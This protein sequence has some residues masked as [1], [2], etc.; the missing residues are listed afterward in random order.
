MI[1][2]S[3]TWLW[4]LLP[5]VG[6]VVYLFTA[7]GRASVV[8]FLSLWGQ[9]TRP[10]RQRDWRMPPLHLLLMLLTLLLTVLAAANPARLTGAGMSEPVSIVLDRGLT[11]AARERPGLALHGLIDRCAEALG[12]I[13]GRVVLISVP[14]ERVELAGSDWVNAARAMAPTVIDTRLEQVVADQLRKTSG[15]VIV[16]SDQQLTISDLRIVQFRPGNSA[17]AVAITLFAARAVPSPSVMVRLEN[18]S[19]MKTVQLLIHWGT[20]TLQREVTLTPTGT[21]QD[22]F[23]EMPANLDSGD[24]IE[25]ELQNAA[26]EDAWGRAYL[27]RQS[28]GIRLSIES[29]LPASVQKLAG[30]YTKDRPAADDALLVFIRAASSDVLHKDGWEKTAGMWVSDEPGETGL[31]ADLV[32]PHAITRNVNAWPFSESSSSAP[33]GFVP[34]VSAGKNDL[35]AVR[36]EPARQVWVSG[37]FRQWEKQIA[38]VVFFAN[39]LEWIVQQKQQYA[40]VEPAMLGSGWQS[41]QPVKVPWKIEPGE[42]PGVYRSEQGKKVAVNAGQLPSVKAAGNREEIL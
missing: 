7:R 40:A 24:T 35:V 38:F 23:F 15:P 1:F 2:V 32:R 42:W 25:A 21:A 41:I 27:V 18:H 22:L 16:L 34:L 9:A 30:V 6:M 36:D 13:D 28:P 17:P 12:P 29:D 4:G 31:T 10:A 8:P 20:Q 39:A 11:T 5:W 14:G 26:A 3:P 37:D 19:K 33:A